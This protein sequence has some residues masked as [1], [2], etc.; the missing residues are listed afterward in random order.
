M[1]KGGVMKF[2]NGG[3]VANM[4]TSQMDTQYTQQNAFLKAVKNMPNPIVSVSDIST[5]QMNVAV[6]ENRSIF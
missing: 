4:I 5:A 3:M 6:I 2:A 1:A